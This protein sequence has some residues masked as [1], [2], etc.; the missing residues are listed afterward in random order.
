M[1]AITIITSLYKPENFEDFVEDTIQQ[2][3]FD[4]NC[5]WIIHEVGVSDKSYR[6]TLPNNCKYITSKKRLSIYQTWNEIIKQSNSEYLA[7][8]NNDD[9]SHS[10]HLERLMDALDFDDTI[11]MAYCPNIETY[12]NNE[13]FN[14]T[15]SN[16]K[17]PCY[18]FDSKNY[19]KNNSAHARP[20]WR[21][22][23]HDEVGYFDESY[24]ICSDY[25]FWLRCIKN[26]KK[27]LK[28]CE[29]PLY[30]YYRNPKGM[31][32]ASENLASAIEEIKQIRKKYNYI[33][34]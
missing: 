18:S 14:N 1:K 26:N 33:N 9:R 31:S 23:L 6:K 24:K 21:K 34:F 3:V 7:N 27:F 30:L 20:M 28:I 5:D 16:L 29:N 8:Y 12:D 17:F 32:S 25:E 2:T 13:N 10:C 11:S 22:S 4:I 15:K 19:W